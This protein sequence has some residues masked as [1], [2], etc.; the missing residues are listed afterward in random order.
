MRSPLDSYGGPCLQPPSQA[1]GRPTRHLPPQPT[2]IRFSLPR[3]RLAGDEAFHL[4]AALDTSRAGVN[5]TTPTAA[6][7]QVWGMPRGRQARAA[8]PQGWAR[9]LPATRGLQRGTCQEPDRVA[10]SIPLPSPAEPGSLPGALPG[11]RRGDAIP[12]LNLQRPP[13]CHAAGTP[14]LL[15]HPCG[16]IPTFQEHFPL[17]TEQGSNLAQILQ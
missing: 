13:D 14:H 1:W 15:Q 17:N 11:T 8:T 7:V 10:G 6:A 2:C 16:C 9:G 12:P 5:G 3:S 4:P